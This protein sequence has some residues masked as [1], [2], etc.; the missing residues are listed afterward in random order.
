MEFLLYFHTVQSRYSFDSSDSCQC[1]LLFCVM[2]LH[3]THS[4]KM[5]LCCTAADAAERAAKQLL[6]TATREMH[7]CTLASYV[8]TREGCT[9]DR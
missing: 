5:L 3:N 2:V 6:S 4:T 9:A 8:I 1:L 7:T